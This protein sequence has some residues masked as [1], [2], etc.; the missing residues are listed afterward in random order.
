[1]D[2]SNSPDS[3]QDTTQPSVSPSASHSHTSATASVSQL[4]SP[5]ISPVHTVSP[6]FHQS[7]VPLEEFSNESCKDNKKQSLSTGEQNLKIFDG[8]LTSSIS[9]AL[10]SKSAEDYSFLFDSDKK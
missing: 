8:T 9:Q 1:S 7:V 2:L 6:P 5:T 4:L 10:K 3:S